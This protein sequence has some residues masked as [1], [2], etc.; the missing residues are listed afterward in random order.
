MK[1]QVQPYTIALKVCIKLALLASMASTEAQVL[2]FNNASPADHYPTLGREEIKTVVSRKFPLQGMSAQ[3][4]PV[5]SDPDMSAPASVSRTDPV[6]IPPM[7]PASNADQMAR[8]DFPDQ[9]ALLNDAAPVSPFSV[10]S[11][12]TGTCAIEPQI[13]PLID[14]ALHPCASYPANRIATQGLRYPFK[15][16]GKLIIKNDAGQITDTGTAQV[17]AGNYL[18]QTLIVTAAHVIW[19]GND[20]RVEPHI[21]F[22][23]AARDGVAPFGQYDWDK[24]FLL[25]NYT[26]NTNVFAAYDIAVL[27]LRNNAIGQPASRYTGKL[28]MHWNPPFIMG[29]MAAGYSGNGEGKGALLTA[30]QTQS[31]RWPLTPEQC[32]DYST[33]G[34]DQVL[35]MGSDLVQGAS[36]GVWLEAFRPFKDT[37]GNYAVSVVSQGIICNGNT[38]VQ[39]IV[40]GP[41]FTTQNIGELCAVAGCAPSSVPTP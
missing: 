8:R 15:A 30:N 7:L 21:T 9:W 6:I 10:N 38:F 14:P 28:G 3:R 37:I 20:K 12:N 22:V 40:V 18:G 1:T 4:S 34:D 24:A 19:D 36:G 29:I 17:I 5:P 26:N 16:I 33:G 2:V 23:P 27:S 13:D 32:P 39:G 35:L 25:S 11:A 41:R 31:F